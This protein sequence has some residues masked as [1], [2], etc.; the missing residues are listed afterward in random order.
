MT[1]SEPTEASV[2]EEVRAWLEAN[3]SPDRGLI[4]WRNML[5]DSA[6]ADRLS[7]D[8]LDQLAEKGIPKTSPH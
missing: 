2:R 7:V 1:M 4:E 5:I 6:H 3:W 8:D